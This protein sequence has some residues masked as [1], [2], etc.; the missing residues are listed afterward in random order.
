MLPLQEG[1]WRPA[2]IFAH[3][4]DDGRI[5]VHFLGLH[6][7]H[8]RW[9]IPSS[10]SECRPLFTSQ[11]P[12]E[13]VAKL[14][15]KGITPQQ[16]NGT[17]KAVGTV[18]DKP[19]PTP[20][21]TTAA[22]GSQ[23]RIEQQGDKA[24]PLP[25]RRSEL[26]W[27]KPAESRHNGGAMNGG[28]I[29]PIVSPVRA[30]YSAAGA[31]STTPVPAPR[32]PPPSTASLTSSLSSMSSSPSSSAPAAPAAADDKQVDVRV[33]SPLASAH[34]LSNAQVEW[35]ELAAVQQRLSEL[36][37][38]HNKQLAALAED[39]SRLRPQPAAETWAELQERVYAKLDACKQQA[40]SETM[41]QQ[42]GEVADWLVKLRDDV[43]RLQDSKQ[44]ELANNVLR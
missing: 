42:L 33:R 22:G 35:S 43:K 36:R 3:N 27:E 20:S 5:Q 11:Y 30:L 28:H 29:H 21:H 34:T 40:A 8:A 1:Q 2:R 32:T 12:D 44:S 17:G 13:W 6:T 16:S 25:I 41:A 7:S 23:Q 26:P 31:Q 19:A 37:L 9:V 14:R 4:K 10:A 39:I 24:P 38:N 18:A 15:A